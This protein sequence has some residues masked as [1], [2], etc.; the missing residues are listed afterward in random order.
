MHVA[1]HLGQSLYAAG[2]HGGGFEAVQGPRH[3]WQGAPAEIGEEL[4]SRG[5]TRSLPD[6]LPAGIG[7]NMQVSVNT[8]ILLPP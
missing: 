3:G 6:H 1:W 7:A 4:G 5:L 8:G 2:W